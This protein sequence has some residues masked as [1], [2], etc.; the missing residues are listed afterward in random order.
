MRRKYSKEK[1]EENQ[2]WSEKKK[3]IWKLILS[4]MKKYTVIEQFQSV[5]CLFSQM[6]FD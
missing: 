4:P 6:Q 1:Q 5:S 3:L 2:N